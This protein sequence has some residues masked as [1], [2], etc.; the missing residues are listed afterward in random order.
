MGRH[1]PRARA[2]NRPAIRSRSL[3]DVNP[4]LAVALVG[5]VVAGEEIPV[6]VEGEFLR[7][8]QAVGEDFEIGAVEFGAEDTAFVGEHEAASLLGQD[9]RGPVAKAEVETSVGSDGEAVH[10]MPGIAEAHAVAPSHRL[11][12]DGVAV[13]VGAF[14]E[15]QFRDVGEPEFVFPRQDARSDAVQFGVELVRVD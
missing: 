9:V 7:I 1:Y 14:E 11:S 3:H 15:R 8:A 2:G 13:G 12:G 5:V 6:F 4:P 10:V